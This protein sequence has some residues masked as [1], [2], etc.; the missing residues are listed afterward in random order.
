M[1]LHRLSRSALYA[2][3]I[4]LAILWILPLAVTM[5]VA[6]KDNVDYTSHPLFALPGRIALLENIQ[7]A[8]TTGTLGVSFINTIL[9]AVVGAGVAIV[10]ASLAAY[11]MVHLHVRGG[12]GWFLL[13]YSGTLFPFQMYLLPLYYLYVNTNLYDTQLGLIVFYIAI[14]VPFCLFVLRNYFTTI[15]HEITE[16]SRLDGLSDFGVYRYI[17]MP[18]SWSALA[19]LFLFQFTW[20]WNELLFGITLARSDTVRPVMAGLAG[21]RGIYAGSNI[22]GILAGAIIASA[23]TIIIFLV[24]RKYLLKGLVLTTA[25]E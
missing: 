14:C 24:L 23:P 22:P 8:W 4:T 18:L 16:A 21:M 2:A 13:I 6:L 5:M 9:Y 17:F 7:W 19:A 3:L 25:G 20:I 1:S 10:V 11:A 12:F 15:P